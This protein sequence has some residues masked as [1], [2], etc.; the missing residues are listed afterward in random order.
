MNS[1]ERVRVAILD[2]HE[3][4]LDGISSWIDSHAPE[5]EIVLRARSWIE[6]VTSDDFPTPLVLMDY[7][8]ADSV[9]IEARIRTCRAAGAR[10]V[11][12]SALDSRESRQRALDAG[13]AAFVSKTLPVAVLVDEARAVMDLRSNGS[14]AVGEQRPSPAETS[15]PRRPAD[16]RLS[17]SE[18]HALRL[19]VQ[20][21]STVAVARAMGVSFETAKTYLRRVREKYAR[22]GRPASRKAELMRRAAE[23][24]YLE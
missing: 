3:L 21:H 6:L 8:L 22:V 5:F 2:D 23:D 14:V 18:E 24:G 19:Y 20:G 9:S 16:P 13:A 12:V 4:I 7:Q 15:A 17:A 11:V 1:D 10:V